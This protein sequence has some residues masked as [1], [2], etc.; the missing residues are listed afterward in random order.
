MR[1]SILE[2]IEHMPS[3]EDGSADFF[4]ACH[5]IEHVRDVL[6]AFE[7]LGRKLRP[8]GQA[9][10]V[11]PDGRHIF[12]SGRPVTTLEHLVADHLVPDRDE[13]DHYLEFFRRAAREPDWIEVALEGQ[14]RGRDVHRHVFSPDSVRDLLAYVQG[15]LE[16]AHAE[17]LEPAHAQELAELYVR[18]TK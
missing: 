15:E 1:V 16:L 17:L 12:D 13:L 18:F 4:V 6:G 5:V 7:E 9:V 8:G 14:R 2:T 10:L 11:I 3:I